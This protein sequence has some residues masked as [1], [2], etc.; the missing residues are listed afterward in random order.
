MA[1]SETGNTAVAVAAPDR[2]PYVDWP[3]IFGG[4]LVAAAIAF[5][6]T[7]FGSA[8]G[9]ALVSPFRPTGMTAVGAA[10]AIGL[11]V[12]WVAGTSYMA[13]GY[14]TGRLRRRIN[15]ATE[16]EVEIR[17]GAHGLIMWG[18]ATLIGAGLIALGVY[19][20]GDVATKGA[21][22]AQATETA[23]GI[24]RAAI[25]GGPRAGAEDGSYAMI[26]E[27]LFG[28]GDEATKPGAEQAR[29]SATAMLAAGAAQGR[30]ADADRDYLVK[31]V[32][33]RSGIPEAEARTRV[34]QAERDS[35]AAAA[36]ARQAA[37]AARKVGVVSAFV[38]AASLLI[39][40][41]GAWWAAGRGGRHRDA[42]TV[43]AWA[44]W[45]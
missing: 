21:A 12:V 36:R 40:A 33:A 34:E 38:I 14:I 42:Q 6:L 23:R 19:G 4:A 13:G 30:L 3:A 15:D 5:V 17:D 24:A 31:L 11:W 8:L 41:V 32:T 44:R 28:P 20:A 35:G 2:A 37:D 9:L 39:G 43:F 18:T 45:P 26:V 25:A 1:T 22:A 7:A 27:R 29:R 16:H 10:I